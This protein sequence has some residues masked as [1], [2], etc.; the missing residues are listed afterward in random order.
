MNSNC[1]HG[2][3]EDRV[4]GRVGCDEGELEDSNMRSLRLGLAQARTCKN[5]TRRT[6]RKKSDRV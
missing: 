3:G 5:W 1:V 6:R 4:G 2:G